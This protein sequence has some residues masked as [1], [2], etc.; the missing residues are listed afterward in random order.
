MNLKINK[1]LTVL[2]MGFLASL[3]ALLI[4]YALFAR[5]VLDLLVNN[6]SNHGLLSV[7]ILG[8]LLLSSVIALVVS[9][10]IVDDV[11]ESSILKSVFMSYVASF[12]VIAL[13]SY[14]SVF[15]VYPEVFYHVNGFE[16]ILEFSQVIVIFSVYMLPHP[17]YLTILN[18][19]VYLLSFIVFLEAYYEK[20]EPKK[21][22]CE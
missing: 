2:V 20:K 4:L 8:L 9:L 12:L 15:I 6:L 19:I 18:Q 13:I 14:I 17:F 5:V 22:N 11:K 10:M 21:I 16:M 3:V 1:I 7:I